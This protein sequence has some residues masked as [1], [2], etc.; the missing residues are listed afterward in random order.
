MQKKGD[1]VA[2]IK[3][4]KKEKKRAREKDRHKL[5]KTVHILAL[6]KQEK[7]KKLFNYVRL[8]LQH[9]FFAIL[10]LLSQKPVQKR[11]IVEKCGFLLLLAGRHKKV[12]LNL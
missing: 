6:H 10:M 9:S 12:T 2:T 3:E 8:V 7:Q 5:A 11:G 4:E 1:K